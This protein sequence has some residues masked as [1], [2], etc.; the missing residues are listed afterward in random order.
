MLNFEVL[1]KASTAQKNFDVALVDY[2]VKSIRPFST[3]SDPNFIDLIKAANKEINVMGRMTLMRRITDLTLTLKQKIIAKFNNAEF[4][5]TAAD[6]WS[7]QHHSYMGISAH[8]IDKNME[9]RSELLA[10]R[11]FPNPHTGER[12][13]EVISAVHEEFNLNESKIVSTVTDNGS[14]IVK[15][16][17][18]FGVRVIDDDGEEFEHDDS[19]E[20]ELDL[21]DIR[22]WLPKHL[23]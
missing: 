16:F 9:R 1:S 8:Y 17:K 5:S 21:A 7:N 11:H 13:A 4:V 10:V 3:V 6:I 22:I 15:A 19:N 14:N 12:I 20:Q 18:D 23:R 2:V